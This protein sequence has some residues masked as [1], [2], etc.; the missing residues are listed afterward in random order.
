M[1]D[2]RWEANI[3]SM[4]F[5]TLY[6]LPNISISQTDFSL[7]IW[8]SMVFVIVAGTPF[9]S[10]LSLRFLT[11]AMIYFRSIF[12]LGLAF[13][14]RRLAYRDAGR[15]HTSVHRQGT[16]EMLRFA[17]RKRLFQLIKGD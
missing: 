3:R 14:Q 4:G 11:L 12:E 1:I 2:G 16:Q 13:R 5:T 8:S 15:R 17:T 7:N 6:L 9:C 10:L